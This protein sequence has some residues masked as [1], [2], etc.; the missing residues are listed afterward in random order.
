MSPVRQ[1]M[2]TTA[3]QLPRRNDFVI[4]CRDAGG[5]QLRYSLVQTMLAYAAPAGDLDVNN[6]GKKPFHSLSARR[7]R[8][9]HDALMQS[10]L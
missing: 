9:K 4:G 6:R 3:A 7:K 1:C 5:L 10:W 2:T 8:T